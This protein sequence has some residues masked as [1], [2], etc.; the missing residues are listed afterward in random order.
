MCDPL[1]YNNLVLF[2]L[3]VDVGIVVGCICWLSSLTGQPL[4]MTKSTF[5]EEETTMSL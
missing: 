3:L 5:L 4:G 1:K 2:L